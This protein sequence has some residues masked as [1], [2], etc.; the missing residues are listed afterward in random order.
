MNLGVNHT[1]EKSQ[2]LRFNNLIGLI[3]G[4]IGSNLGNCPILN[5]NNFG[6]LIP[7][8]EENSGLANE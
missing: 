5:L 4:E 7:V 2:P 6:Q 3:W 1:G 8:R